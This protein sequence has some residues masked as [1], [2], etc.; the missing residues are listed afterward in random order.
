MTQ[1][2]AS[3]TAA[4]AA[5]AIREGAITSEELVSACLARI[6]A[7]EPLIGAWAYLDRDYA[8]EQARRADEQRREGRPVG[9][10]HG[11]PVG[12]KDIFETMDMPTEN[13]TVLHAGYR[14]AT[15]AKAVSLLREAGAVIMGKTVTTELAVYA[16][17]KTRNPHDANRTP[18]GSS[19][20]SAAAVAA[21]MVPLAIGSQTNGS[22]IRPASFCGVFGFKPTH[23]LISRHGMLR[24][25]RRLDH[26]GVFARSLEDVALLAECLMAYDER[27]PDMRLRARPRLTQVMMEEPP[28]APRFAFVKTPFWEQT[29]EDT[30]EGFAELIAC[31]QGRVEELAL[32]EIF[33]EAV[34]WHRTIME[35]DLARSFQLEYERGRD[36]LSPQLVEMIERGRRVLAVDY[37]RAVDRIQ[38]LNEILDDY[39]YQYDAFLTPAAPGEA[40]PGLESTGNPIFCTLWTLCG[41]PALCLP[42]LTGRHGLPIGVQ[43]VGQYGDDARLLRT[44][45][46]LERR[47]ATA[48]E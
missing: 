26:V 27:D 23:G 42:L 33:Q 25:S 22:V 15:D 19:S 3:L 32:S 29:E 36:R 9:P 4:R 38:L 34:Q 1:E 16:P 43:L 7:R 10:L 31:L 14:P 21:D 47:L 37:N 20:G 28:V 8:L 2:L 41:V 12:V 11:V 45:R 17:G 30:R 24:Q 48:G 40:P 13:G 6:E 35:A 5:E 18:G 39:F 44:A 46:W